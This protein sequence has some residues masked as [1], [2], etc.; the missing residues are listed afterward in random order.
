[1]APSTL[2]ELGL[3][4]GGELG[5]ELPFGVPHDGGHQALASLSDQP[6]ELWLSA[7]SCSC[8]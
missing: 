2:A 7:M 4:L 3:L 1:M 6:D 8:S 5:E